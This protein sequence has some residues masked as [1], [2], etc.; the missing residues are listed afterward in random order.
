MISTARKAVR[1]TGPERRSDARSRALLA[2]V[3][4]HGAGRNTVNCTVRDLTEDGAHLKLPASDFIKPPFMLLVL[5]A[6]EA[7]DAK[8]VWQSRD[9]IGMAFTGRR[10]LETPETDDDR[11]ARRLWIESRPRTGSWPLS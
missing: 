11:I 3:L 4:F 6:G 7:Y 9:E 5:S 10:N 2:G 1:P 8:I